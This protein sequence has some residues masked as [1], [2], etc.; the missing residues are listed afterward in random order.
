MTNRNR[1]RLSQLSLGLAIAL[2]AAPAFAQNTTASVT[3]RIVGSDA[4]PVT[5]A[6]VTIVHT[7][8]GTVSNATTGNDGRYSARGLRVGGPYTITIIKDGVTE[9]R[10]GVY[11]QLAETTAV[12]ATLV[13]DVAT[14]AAVEVTGSSVISEVFSP[15]KMG[16]GSNVNRSQIE[17]LPSA[18][19]NIQDYIRTDPRISQVSKAD[20]AI[21][22]GGQNT[23]Y[24][25]IKIDGVS[26]S[27]PF[28]LESNNL[29]TERQPV[30]IDAIEEI[31]IDL[32]NY[33]TTIAG[34]TGAVVNA[35]T[36]SGTNEFHGSL[37]YTLRD[38]D[39]VREDLEG[40]KFNG[41][42]SEETYG[43]TFGGPLL[44][45]R[46]FFFVNY[47]NYTR[48]DTSTG[49]SD[50]PYG[51]GRITDQNIADVQAAAASHGFNAGNITTAADAEIEEYA[52]KLDWNISDA[53]RA[54][55]RYSSMTQ[56]VP[57]FPQVDNN[58]I[59]LSTFWYNHNKEFEST[60][61]ELFS[62]WTDNFSTE[63]KVSLRDYTAVREP[64]S[65]L[66][67]VEVRG[68]TGNSSIYLGTEQNTHVNVLETEQ[69]TVF[70]AGNLFIGNHEMK[71]GFDHES[72]DI[73]NYYG[74][75]QN[76]TYVF[77][78]LQA[79]V[80]GTPNSYI[81]RAPLPGSSFEDIAA[82]YTQ[83]NLG[84]F[85]QDTWSV[86]YNLTLMFGLRF[87]KPDF[88]EQPRFNP[89]IASTYGY[90]NT[91]TVDASLI[92]PRAGFNYTFDSD[93][94]TQ[95]RGG[96]GLFQ[97]AAPNVWV[98]GAYGNTGLNYIEY[99]MDGRSGN[100]P[101]PVF[102]PSL[103]A[104]V[105]TSGAGR[106]NVD[107]IE[108]GFAL[109]SVWKAN[110]AF[111]H[112]LPWHGIVFSAEVLRTNVKDGIVIDRLDMF[113]AA[114]N[115]ATAIGPDGRFI[116]WT[117]QGL[118]PDNRGNFGMENN[119]GRGTFDRAYRPAGVGD[120]FLIRN[121]DKGE[122]S[123]LTVGFDKPL[124]DTWAWSL[125]Y[126]YTE[127][128]DVTPLTSSQN[129]S[130][131][132]STLIRNQGED[133][134]Y[135][136]RYAIK[137]RITGTVTWR[138]NFFQNYETRVSMFY[139]GRSGRPFSYIFRNDANGDGGGFNDLFYVPMGPGD[140][141]W[142]GGSAMEQSFFDWL[143][144]NP[145]LKAYQGKVAPA[146]AFRTQWVNSFDVRIT[147]ELPG[148]AEGHKSVLALDIMNIGNLLNKEWGIIEDYGFNSTQQLAN[149]AGICGPG[150]TFAG[151]AGNDGKYV[152]HWTGP[153]A[154]AQI[155]ENNNDK[156]NTAV[157]RWSAMLSFKYQF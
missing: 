35:V 127:A 129:S 151:C 131:W 157:S 155:Q 68:F 11:L 5:G 79:F 122:S 51:S 106:Q 121:T 48:A 90:D 54:A 4:Q 93:R 115:G 32:A 152:Y 149:Y 111:E 76:G 117:T 15:E 130:N 40:S 84:L 138:H 137:D 110:I 50:S 146:N 95:I 147:Q 116:Y 1:V 123:Q 136:S 114:G 31:N 44:K 135:D 73:F 38:G 36:R 124:V 94:P 56:D 153:G 29:P 17:A 10:E 81:V 7:P 26:A 57:R 42:S 30:S 43:A 82:Q 85:V 101:A 64:F 113:D 107:I 9:V 33:D 16:T 47:E 86:N 112:E 24:N 69:V 89:L 25:L 133:V 100:P 71:F 60:V 88:D 148:F 12:D 102:D 120:V 41:F 109:P 83:K 70:G 61:A 125:F 66:P 98:A 128:T 139:E 99:T 55:L 39:W 156:G 108:P 77:N 118:N 59:S 2:A 63:L 103:P 154:G 97:G 96:L 150:V 58:S 62:D 134:A 3:G 19:R 13:D 141:V 105:P 92:Q 144:Q 80:N 45:D 8:S 132:G 6:Q 67:H 145:E 34:G 91:Q 126:T 37:Y 142:T 143:E 14:L 87:D 20:G 78:N 104:F 21:S 28:G 53:H 119:A 74:R 27:D 22:A 23:R 75:N 49:F 52:I 65:A 18:N 140:V 72:N 46:L